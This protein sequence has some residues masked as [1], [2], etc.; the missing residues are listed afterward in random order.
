MRLPLLEAATSLRLT[1]ELVHDPGCPNVARA[2][3]VLSRT[4]QEAGLPAVWTEWSTD[5]ADCPETY[6]GF[7]SPTILV[8]GRDVAPGPHPWRRR[9]LRDGPRTR[10]YEDARGGLDGVPPTEAIRHAIEEAVGPDAG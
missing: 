5:D 6:R 1:I 2:R 9:Q 7:G 8:N 4:L 3:H 10:R